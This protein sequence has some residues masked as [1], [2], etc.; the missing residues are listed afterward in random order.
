MKTSRGINES[1]ATILGKIKSLY[2]SIYRIRFPLMIQSQ[3]EKK[4]ETHS[5]SCL[6]CLVSSDS[7]KLFNSYNKVVQAEGDTMTIQLAS[8]FI[9]SNE[10]TS[11][12]HRI[13]EQKYLPQNLANLDLYAFEAV[14]Q[15]TCAINRTKMGY[16]NKSTPRERESRKRTPEW[17]P[18]SAGRE[19]TPGRGQ[20]PGSGSRPRSSSYRKYDQPYS[21]Q[22]QR[23]RS[24]S[25]DK[26]KGCLRCGGDHLAE[27]CTL[28]YSATKCPTGCGYF[29]KEQ[30]CPRKKSSTSRQSRS[31]FGP[32]MAFRRYRTPGGRSTSYTR[33]DQGQKYRE[34]VS[35]GG[36]RYRE[37]R[38]RSRSGDNRPTNTTKPGTRQGRSP[39]RPAAGPAYRVQTLAVDEQQH[40]HM[41]QQ[42]SHMDEY[43]ISN[44]YAST[45]SN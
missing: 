18:R 35:P 2:M 39:S 1:V 10:S 36:S 40:S 26:I 19:R 22:T 23:P 6:H 34:M 9:T 33:D 37:F 20:S 5:L 27:K 38:R 45:Q 4:A 8:S 41:E 29:H 12:R 24:E 30:D 15:E 25:R 32:R 11:P 42:H 14:G 31:S 7:M 28:E 43:N 16:D 17:R 21:R 3:I 44:L 13:T